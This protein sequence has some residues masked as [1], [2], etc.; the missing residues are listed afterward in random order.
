MKLT[1]LV[2]GIVLAM[3]AIA[4]AGSGGPGG[5]S[6]GGDTKGGKGGKAGSGGR[7]GN[8]KGG[9]SKAGPS[10]AKGDGGAAAKG[11]SSSSGAVGSAGNSETKVGG[12]TYVFSGNT[13]G[14]GD[15]FGG[16]AQNV[17]GGSGGSGGASGASIAGAG[18]SGGNAAKSGNGGS[19][20]PGG[21]AGPGDANGGKA[22]PGGAAGPGGKGGNGG[23]FD[24]SLPPIPVRRRA[25]DLF[26]KDTNG[27]SIYARDESNGNL[28]VR[29]AKTAIAAAAKA[30]AGTPDSGEITIEQIVKMIVNKE[31]WPEAIHKAFAGSKMAQEWDPPKNLGPCDP[32]LCKHPSTNAVHV[33][34]TGKIPGEIIAA[35]EN[36][37]YG[38]TKKGAKSV[39]GAAG[40]PGGPG[41]AGTNGASVKGASTAGAPGTVKAGPP[42]G[43]PASKGSKPKRNARADA[44]IYDSDL[45]ARYAYPEAFYDNELFIRDMDDSYGNLFSRDAEP[46]YHDEFGLYARNA[47]VDFDD[48]FSAYARDAAPKFDDYFGIYERDAEAWS[49]DGEISARDAAPAPER[50]EVAHMTDEDMQKMLHTLQTNKKAQAAVMKVVNEDPYLAHYAHELEDNYD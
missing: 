34:N 36:P 16:G 4:E 49:D 12:I 23:A 25:R 39:K 28:L 6:K 14:N 21:K 18:G 43:A 27:D 15:T 29:A 46:E 35:I 13:F 19:S 32:T 5:S 30:G 44:S 10:I 24:L 1:V 38:W 37:T 45:F 3:A 33:L 8:S 40:G 20:G 9:D 22:G 31:S 41:A 48:D 47:D 26:V 17:E 42:A 50:E 2:T 11:G 7:G